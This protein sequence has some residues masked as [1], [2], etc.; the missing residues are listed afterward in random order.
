MKNSNPQK[1]RIAAIGKE[2]G[3]ET[4]AYMQGSE[5]NGTSKEAK[6]KQWM[7]LY[8]NDTTK[9]SN[10]NMAICGEIH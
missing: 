4:T 10:K 3:R 9:K 1:T 5:G 8:Y 6:R 7:L 2:K